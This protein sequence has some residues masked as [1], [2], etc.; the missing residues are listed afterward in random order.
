MQLTVHDRK[1]VEARR[2]TQ[3]RDKTDRNGS[4]ER[5]AHNSALKSKREDDDR[6][7]N[8]NRSNLTKSDSKME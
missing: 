7:T 5:V 3:G 8:G 2:S 4:V 6:R 1:M